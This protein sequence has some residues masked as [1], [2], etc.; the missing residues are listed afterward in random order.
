VSFY[1]PV[2]YIS[3]KFII[4][5]FLLLFQFGDTNCQDHN[6][7]YRRIIQKNKIGKTYFNRSKIRAASIWHGQNN[8]LLLCLSP[9]N[10][11]TELNLA[12]WLNFY[13]LHKGLV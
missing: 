12:N 10:D 1:E 8:V 3:V 9:L 6:S 5:Y 13:E 2:S 7:S 11:W 4:M